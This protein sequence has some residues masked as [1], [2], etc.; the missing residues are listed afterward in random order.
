MNDIDI[1]L[2]H[3]LEKRFFLTLRIDSVPFHSAS[4]QSINVH[5][6]MIVQQW[7]SM[8]MLKTASHFL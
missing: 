7:G 3:G 6:A 1:E 2:C 4:G 8:T 5:H